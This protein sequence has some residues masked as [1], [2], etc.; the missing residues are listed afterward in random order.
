MSDSRWQTSDQDTNR[1]REED[2]VGRVLDAI[3]QTNETAVAD[4]QLA[5]P[6]RKRR[7]SGG[8]V[9]DCETVEVRLLI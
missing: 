4:F 2:T 3:G 9:A 5:P 6:A 1:R 7:V 8:D